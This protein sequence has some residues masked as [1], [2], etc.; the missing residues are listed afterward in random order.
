MKDLM[1]KGEK[2]KEKSDN[3]PDLLPATLKLNNRIKD[4][5]RTDRRTYTGDL[6]N[7]S[8]MCKETATLHDC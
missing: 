1:R 3:K 5:R 8:K 4:V 2:Y 7:Q 6:F